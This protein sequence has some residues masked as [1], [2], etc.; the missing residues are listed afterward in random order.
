MLVGILRM[1]FWTSKGGIGRWKL[2]EVEERFM[3]EITS[4]VVCSSRVVKMKEHLP[5]C[6]E[7]SILCIEDELLL[8]ILSNFER[9]V[10]LKDPVFWWVVF[11]VHKLLWSVYRLII[12]LINL[13]LHIVW[14]IQYLSVVACGLIG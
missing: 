10:A 9:E 3:V 1:I 5:F 11:L 7:F 4:L 8:T 2:T 14:Y 13:A 12:T 6:R